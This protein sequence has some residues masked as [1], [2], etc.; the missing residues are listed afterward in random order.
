M[1][2]TLPEGLGDSSQLI[3]ALKQMCKLYCYTDLP[4]TG[5]L[6]HRCDNGTA[7]VLDCAWAVPGADGGGKVN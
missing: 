1:L 4:D 6:Q 2:A 5:L 3:A 7:F